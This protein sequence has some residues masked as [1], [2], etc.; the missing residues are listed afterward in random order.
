[1]RA[2]I[3]GWMSALAANLQYSGWRSEDVP[4]EFKLE[5]KLVGLAAHTATGNEKAMIQYGE[6]IAPSEPAR[7]QQVLEGLESSVFSRIPGRPDPSQVRHLVVVVRQDLTA[8]AYIN[9]LKLIAQVKVTRDVNAGDPVFSKDI[10]E[11]REVS[12]GID[13]P[14]DAAVIVVTCIGWR[15]SVYFDFGPFTEAKTRI[16]PLPQL[17]A[18]QMLMLFGL[19]EA[20]RPTRTRVDSMAD[21]FQSLQR[22]LRDRCEEEAQYQALLEAHPW[23]LGGT[24]SEVTGHTE[25]GHDARGKRNIPDLT[26]TRS[27]DE[28]HDIIE[29]KQP[30]LSCFRE[31]GNF[32]AEFNDSWNQAERYL[33]AARED[34]DYLERHLGLRF[35]NPKCLLITGHDWSEAQMRAVRQKESVNLSI[36][37]LR[38]DQL[39]AQATQVLSLM[40][41]A[42]VP[43]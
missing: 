37:V 2:L 42:S 28:M 7:V 39:V 11:V 13:V 24:Y 30:F 8:T 25:H 17:L 23:M 32:S 33:I 15:R 35:E 40:R 16:A 26:A 34:R 18:R 22:L 12:L 19:D 27:T 5:E 1:M 41:T 10:S 4:I 9:E 20:T 43:E 31:D 21:G 29:L 36:T 38:W 3:F 14:D 6:L